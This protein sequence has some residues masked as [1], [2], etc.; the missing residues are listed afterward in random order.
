MVRS[1]NRFRAIASWVTPRFSLICFLCLGGKRCVVAAVRLSFRVSE[2]R[3]LDSSPRCV[4]EDIREV[5]YIEDG[6]L[7]KCGSDVS[8]SYLGWGVVKSSYPATA[9]GVIERP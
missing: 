1:T 3:T 2:D 7:G 4:E 5:V 8:V 9:T 6:L